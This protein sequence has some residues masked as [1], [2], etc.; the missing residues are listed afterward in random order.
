[1][2]CM[3]VTSVIYELYDGG[4]SSLNKQIITRKSLAVS[5]IS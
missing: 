5:A 1:M 4:K 2:L 3:S